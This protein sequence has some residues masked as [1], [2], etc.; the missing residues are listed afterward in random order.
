MFRKKPF[1]V[2]LILCST[3]LLIRC[4]SPDNPKQKQKTTD[5]QPQLESPTLDKPVVDSLPESQEEVLDDALENKLEQ[6]NDLLHETAD[7]C[8]Y[9]PAGIAADEKIPVVFIFDPHAKARQALSKYQSLADEFKFALIASKKSKNQQTLQEGIEYYREMHSALGKEIP[10]KAAS[11]YTMGFSGGARVAVSVAIEQPEV[12]AVIGCGAG[13]PALQQLPDSKFYYFA[14]AGYEDFNLGELI[15]NNRLLSRSGFDN[16]LVIFD[17]GHEWPA[18]DVMREAFMAVALNAMKNKKVENDKHHIQKA[19]GFYDSTMD[20]FAAKS[21]YFDAV[22]TAERAAS[23][24][25]GLADVATFKA[26]AAEYK[27]KPTYKKDLTAMVKSLE[28]ESGLQNQYLQD[29]DTKDADWWKNEITRLGGKGEDVFQTRLLRRIHAYLGLAAYSLSHRAIAADDMLRAQRYIDIYWML[30]PDNPET[31]YLNAIVMMHDGD[32]A[33][34]KAYIMQAAMLGFD[35][36]PRFATETAFDSLE[37][38]AQLLE[39]FR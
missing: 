18:Q 7:F 19:I 10:V 39:M 13:F 12:E 24:L 31:A 22:E 6:K 27:K 36:A 28:E 2:F 32:A 26:Q 11:I 25:D 23:I 38:R 34:A 5:K 30:E 16:E 4:A 9:L 33:A 14:I 20:G 8:W 29:F 35:D 21:R 1:I 3:F 37:N 17:G 15:N